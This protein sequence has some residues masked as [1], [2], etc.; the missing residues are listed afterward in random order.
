M[1]WQA[2]WPHLEQE[3]L[4]FVQRR[5]W[6]RLSNYWCRWQEKVTE[7]SVG[8]VGWCWIIVAYGRWLDR[9]LG[10]D[11][12]LALVPFLTAWFNGLGYCAILG[13]L[14]HWERC[15][16]VAM[17]LQSH[18]LTHTSVFHLPFRWSGSI[19]SF[20]ANRVQRR[21]SGILASMRGLQKD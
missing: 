6:K 10:G 21:E 1:Y 16:C 15:R 12:M 7:Y 4:L 8:S 3:R 20:P 2:N 5:H 9:C 13:S 19:Q 17:A 18:P 11:C 14:P